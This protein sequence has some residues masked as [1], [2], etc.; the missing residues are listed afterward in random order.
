MPSSFCNLTAKWGALREGGVGALREIK[1]DYNRSMT[2]I[3]PNK[4]PKRTFA[5]YLLIL[6]SLIIAWFGVLRVQQTIA[7][8]EL[9]NALDM[10]ARNPFWIGSGIFYALAGISAAMAL[11]FRRWWAP[12][13][14]PTAYFLV[15][16]LY[17]I[18]HLLLTQSPAAK[19]NIPF[20][21]LLNVFLFFFA[22]VTLAQPK[23]LRFFNVTLNNPFTK[24]G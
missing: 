12:W 23:Q 24:K 15:S 2:P 19:G 16:L 13:Y 5:L 6:A 9:I 10:N 18:E 21:I 7:N 11:F 17:W 1:K 3:K 14:A 22:L 8:I 4:K 20:G